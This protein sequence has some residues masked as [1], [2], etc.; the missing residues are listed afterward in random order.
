[1]IS[2]IVCVETKSKFIDDIK[3][4]S[5]SSMFSCVDK[6]S[7]ILSFRSSVPTFLDLSMYL[8]MILIYSKLI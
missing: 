4:F 6:V 2:I 3:L 5:M 7:S 8:K 1:M